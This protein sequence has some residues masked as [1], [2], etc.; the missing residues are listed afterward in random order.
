MGLDR[1]AVQ[2]YAEW[3]GGLLT[4]DLG[5]S[6]AGFAAGGE[7]PIW[8]EIDG[9]IYNTF[10]LAAVTTLFMVPLSLLLGVLAAVRAGRPLDHGISLGSLALVSR[11]RVR[12]RLAADRRLLQLAGR[13]A[14]RLARPARVRARSTIRRLS[15]CPC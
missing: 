10:V 14:A 15:C 13:A 1:P 2:R 7:R 9:K 11:A 5:N 3:L 8:N 12:G 6:A 4:A